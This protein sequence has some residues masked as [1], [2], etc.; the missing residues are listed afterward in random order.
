MTNHPELLVMAAQ[1]VL[2]KF[3]RNTEGVKDWME[4]IKLELNEIDSDLVEEETAEISQM[5]G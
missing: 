2:E 1:C 4:A 5:G 3:Q